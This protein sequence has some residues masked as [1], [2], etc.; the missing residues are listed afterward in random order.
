MNIIHIMKDGTIRD[1]IDG[2]IVP[3]K[4]N[5]PVYD[6]IKGLHKRGIHNEHKKKSS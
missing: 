6:I 1:D 5:K 2:L 3:F 4:E